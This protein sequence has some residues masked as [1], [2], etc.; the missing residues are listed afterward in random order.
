MNP[1]HITTTE[2]IEMLRE[3]ERTHGVLPVVVGH[4][5]IASVRRSANGQCAEIVVPETNPHKK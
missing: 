5:F 4:I 3:F 2:L 1:E